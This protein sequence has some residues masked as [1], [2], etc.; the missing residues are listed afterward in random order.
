M[1]AQGVNPGRHSPAPQCRRDAGAP[2]GGNRGHTSQGRRTP[3]L[4]AAEIVDAHHNAG[5]TPAPPADESAKCRSTTTFAAST[6][7][8]HFQRALSP[9]APAV[10]TFNHCSP[11]KLLLSPANSSAF[12]ASTRYPRGIAVLSPKALAGSTNSEYIGRMSTIL[13]A[14]AL[15]KAYGLV[16]SAIKLS[17]QHASSSSYGSSSPHGART[18]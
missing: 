18:R 1:V 17:L 11:R 15:P 10:R 16:E 4:P 7:I 14:Q 9:R 12:S 6:A 13:P 3:A 5:G 8:L 2:S